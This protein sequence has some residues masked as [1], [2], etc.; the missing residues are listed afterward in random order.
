MGVLG[1]DHGLA[2]FLFIC[3]FFCVGFDVFLFD[4]FRVFYED[5]LAF[6]LT[7]IGPFEG[8]C[9]PGFWKANPRGGMVFETDCFVVASRDFEKFSMLHPRSVFA[10]LE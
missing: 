8:L 5:L 6:D 4:P 2:V 10:G 1:W 9:F 7:T 3:V